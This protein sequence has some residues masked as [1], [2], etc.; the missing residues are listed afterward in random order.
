MRQRISKI[1]IGWPHWSGPLLLLLGLSVL[2][3]TPLFAPGYFYNAHDG[4]H[5]V[6]YLVQFDASIRDGVLWPRWAMHHTQGY[7]YP[8]F[9]IQAPLGFYLAELFIL[10]GAGYTQAA[11]LSWAVGSIAGGLGIYLLVETLLRR[12]LKSVEA[13]PSPTSEANSHSSE[14]A[15]SQPDSAQRLIARLIGVASGLLYVFIPYHLL[16]MYVRAALNDTLLLGWFPWV[17]LAF[18]YLMDKGLDR[19]WIRRLAIAALCLGAVLLTHAFAL[20]SFTPLLISFVLFRLGFV[21]WQYRDWARTIRVGLLACGAG[22]SA[23]LLYANFLLP[24][25]LEGSSHLQQQVYVADTYDFHRHFVYWGQFFSPFWGFGFSDDPDGAGDGMGFQIGALALLITIIALYLH[26]Q[27]FPQQLMRRRIGDEAFMR[28]KRRAYLPRAMSF[29]L[30]LVTVGL[31][32]LMTPLSRPLWESVALLAVIQFPWRLLALASFTISLL[33]GLTMWHF[34]Q[35]LYPALFDAFAPTN[36]KG[37]HTPNQNG[38]DDTIAGVMMVGILA[39]YGSYGY[40][41]ANLDPVEAWREDGRAIVFFEREHPDMMGYTEWVDGEIRESPMTANYLDEAYR[42]DYT[43]VGILDRLLIVDGQGEVLS[44]YSRGSSAGGVVRL[45][46]PATVRVLVYH[47]PG[48]EVRVNGSQVDH[49][50]STPEGLIE[51]SL[52]AGEHHIDARMG[53]TP[54]RRLSGALSGITFLVL[55]AMLFVQRKANS[56]V[57]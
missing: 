5:S 55:L 41:Q 25:L 40:V 32:V 10:L 52:P 44:R 7:G 20:I 42:E 50:I 13:S 1:F 4:R 57:N 56:D 22:L 15:G 53:N 21:H 33:A 47:F 45:D 28:L 29:Y 17:F 11:K 34:C 18:E 14:L 49:T 9:I 35:T 23:L 2:A 48:W 8:T 6:F 54:L 36:T 19:G 12:T 27:N 38:A 46:E 30:I 16:D 24:L 26:R 51:V 43:K 37:V 31:L 39:I 3:I